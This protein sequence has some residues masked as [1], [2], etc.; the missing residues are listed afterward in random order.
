MTNPT[1]P[2]SPQDRH[3]PVTL[4]PAP[5]RSRSTSAP[6]EDYFGTLSLQNKVLH[7][8]Q[9]AKLANQFDV[10]ISASGGGVSGSDRAIQLGIARALLKTN[11]ELK[12]LLREDSLLTRDPRK[13]ER[14]KARSTRR[15]QALPVL[16]ALIREGYPSTR[17]LSATGSEFSSDP[18]FVSGAT[19]P[20]RWPLHPI[21]ADARPGSS[22]PPGP[23]VPPGGPF[24]G[25]LRPE[26]P[27]VLG[28]DE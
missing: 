23:R 11:P 2:P 6:F 8:F 20:D 14:K 7:P 19:V 18:C 13:K 1:P 5:A 26:M 10:T 28:I 27:D 9:T 3:R 12:D 4:V 22:S 24:R 15:P 21:R 17:N 16:E 25:A